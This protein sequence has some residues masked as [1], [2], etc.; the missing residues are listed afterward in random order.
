MSDPW[1]FMSWVLVSSLCLDPYPLLLFP[2]F[3]LIK[4]TALKGLGPEH[5]SLTSGH[6][7][8]IT[9]FIQQSVHKFS[10]AKFLLVMYKLFLLPW[11]PWQAF[12]LIE[13]WFP[14][15]HHCILMQ[16][17]RNSSFEAYT[18]FHL[19]YTAFSGGSLSWVGLLINVLGFQT[20]SMNIHRL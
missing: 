19:L 1:A 6:C 15:C 8:W 13:L 12:I 17:F 18:C 3:S 20:I 10:F 14:W 5:F 2:L 16:C 9:P 4:H 11:C 7:C